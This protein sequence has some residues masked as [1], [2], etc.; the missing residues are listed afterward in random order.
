M[1]VLVHPTAEY[2]MN[3]TGIL[4][5]EHWRVR[6]SDPTSSQYYTLSQHFSEKVPLTYKHIHSC[7]LCTVIVPECFSISMWCLQVSAALEK[8]NEFKSVSVLDF[9]CVSVGN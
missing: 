5:G 8:L 1:A 7:T 4:K 3:L 2:R 6:L 9:R